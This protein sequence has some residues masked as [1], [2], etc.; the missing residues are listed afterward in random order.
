MALTKSDC[1]V[2]LNNLKQEGNSD[3]QLY[4]KKLLTNADIPIEVIKYINDNRQFDLTEFYKKIRQS[5]NH[6]K[7]KL[8]KEILRDKFDK[9]ED[10]LKTLSS[11]ALQILLYSS[12][13]KNK[14][15][16][17][18]SARL[19]EIYRCLYNYTQT[20][21]LIPCYK[22]ISLIKADLLVC[23]KVYRE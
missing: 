17:L 23:E 7:S 3:T 14:Q 21:D 20:Y 15:I 8:Y 18:R 4:I 10:I 13:V 19:D 12:N 1:L 2:L 5:Y 6:K 16:F 11:L 22:L 9:Q